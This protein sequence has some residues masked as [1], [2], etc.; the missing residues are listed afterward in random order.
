MKI[1]NPWS[2]IAL[3]F[4]FTPFALADDV[5]RGQPK[6]AVGL[7]AGWVVANGLSY[8]RY[9]DDN[10][11]QATFAGAVDRKSDE[12]YVDVSLSYARYLKKIDLESWHRLGLKFVGGIEAERD[13]WHGDSENTVFTGAGFGVDVGY[14]GESGF[15][16]AFDVIYTAGFDYSSDNGGFE[17]NSLELLPSLSLHFNL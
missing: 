1:R 2:I 15:V 16:L 3:S 8:R 7:S 9:F 4:L 5:Q 13:K 10:L 6:H 14:V 17:F 12:E 11:V